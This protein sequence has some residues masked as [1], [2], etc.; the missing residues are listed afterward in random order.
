MAHVP[1]VE[2]KGQYRDSREQILNAAREVFEDGWFILGPRVERFEREFAEYCGVDGAVG[3]GSGTD[4]L[5]LALRACGVGPGDEV[6]TVANTFVATVLA[7]EWVGARPVLVEVRPESGLVDPAAVR[8]AISSRTRALLPVHLFGQPVDLAPLV[9][10]ARQ[11]GLVLIEDACQ[12]HG[13]EYGGGRVGAFGDVGCFSF[14]PTK[15]L[16]AFGDGGLVVSRSPEI[17]DRVRR[18]RNY[19]QT[20]KYHHESRGFNTRLDELQAALLSTK[21]PHLDR[22]NERRR[23]IAGRYAA[24]I[25]NPAVTPLR[26]Q[27]GRRHVYHVFAVRCARRDALAHRLREHGVETLIHYPVPIHLQPAFRDLGL[28]PGALPETEA[29]CR[30]VLSLPMYPELEDSQVDAVIRCVN[31]FSEDAP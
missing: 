17:L 1:F 7:V 18:L 26:E 30:E 5:H 9:D 6:I 4:A 29:F 13:A 21:L 2:L 31:A 10:L 19:G 22:W 28:G 27:P 16:G 8:A 24:G 12:A 3:V 14:Y 23:Q 25:A 11:H 20:S 15:N